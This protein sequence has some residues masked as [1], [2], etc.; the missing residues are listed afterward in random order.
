MHAGRYAARI[1][2]STR[3]SEIARS[4]F[5]IKSNGRHVT[6]CLQVQVHLTHFGPRPRP[7]AG[8]RWTRTTRRTQPGQL[9]GL[10]MPQP[11][12]L[13]TSMPT[14]RPKPEHCTTDAH[15]SAGTAPRKVSHTCCCTLP[16]RCCS[17][18][19]SRTSQPLAPSGSNTQ[20]QIY[21]IMSKRSEHGI[22]P[23]CPAERSP[24]PSTP[25]RGPSLP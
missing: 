6:D 22:P 13:Q 17:P 20:P 10:R 21:V 9:Q 25:L 24:C 15:H 1:S 2:S 11:V 16:P 19:T 14:T 18:C 5:R 12:I 3:E 23:A 4:A 7:R 8:P